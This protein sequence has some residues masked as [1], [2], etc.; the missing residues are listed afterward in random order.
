MSN[1]LIKIDENI[2][3][4]RIIRLIKS[5]KKISPKKPTN[6]QAM[7][8]YLK[9]VVDEYC[10]ELKRIKAEE[11]EKEMEQN[12]KKQFELE[13]SRNDLDNLE[14]SISETEARLEASMDLY[15]KSNPIALGILRIQPYE[16]PGKEEKSNE[17][18]G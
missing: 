8:S 17:K 11:I 9:S 2:L 6:T 7:V 10:L 12:K 13:K 1:Y 18:N 3:Q 5:I 4:R 15:N 16:T 14:I